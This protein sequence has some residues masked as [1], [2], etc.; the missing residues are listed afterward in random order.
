MTTTKSTKATRKPAA[1]VAIVKP[2]N[3]PAAV[4]AKGLAQRKADAAKAGGEGTTAEIGV[5]LATAEIGA[6]S[7][8]DSLSAFE[9]KFADAKADAK[10]KDE[11]LRQTFPLMAR[12]ALD[13]NPTLSAPKPGNNPARSAV[14]AAVESALG[15]SR[16]AAQARVARWVGA[17]SLWLA[18]GVSLGKAYEI[19]NNHLNGNG[20]AA[21]FWAMVTADAVPTLS[22]QDGKRKAQPKAGTTKPVAPVVIPVAKAQEIVAAAKVEAV[23]KMTPAQRTADALREITDAYTRLMD[24]IKAGTHAPLTKANQ[25]RVESIVKALSA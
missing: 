7:A 13:L 3:D 12:L 15:I 4:A 9:A 17:G 2:A 1:P 24:G 6:E 5:M 21:A 18:H 20:D 22:Q 10:A 8:H 19:A 23:E 16:K 11:A 25:T 14:V